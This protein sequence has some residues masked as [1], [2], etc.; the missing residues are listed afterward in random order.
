[1]DTNRLAQIAAL[2]H[3]DG[4]AEAIGRAIAD[5]G[6]CGLLREGEEDI[7]LEATMSIHIG[8]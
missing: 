4:V 3:T 2:L 1:M 8:L 7:L 5:A 6:D